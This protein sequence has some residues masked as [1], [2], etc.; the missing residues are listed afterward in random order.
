MVGDLG[1]AVEVVG[2]CH[3]RPRELTRRR[4]AHDG[5]VGVQLVHD[6]LDG[7]E[8]AVR[9]LRPGDVDLDR[10]GAPVGAAAL[11]DAV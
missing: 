8:G 5:F 3:E 6:D 7:F 1:D 10:L 2:G 9:G 11:N 4:G